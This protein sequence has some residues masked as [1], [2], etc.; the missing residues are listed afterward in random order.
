MDNNL[1]KSAQAGRIAAAASVTL[2]FAKAMQTTMEVD[3]LRVPLGVSTTINGLDG[4][5]DLSKDAQ[6][7][8]HVADLRFRKI[9]GTEQRTGEYRHPVGNDADIAWA[10]SAV[11]KPPTFYLADMLFLLRGN[12]VSL[13]ALVSLNLARTILADL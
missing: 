8:C 2:A 6:L 7:L 4:S 13:V 9:P 10:R 1:V 5:E 11:S 12:V 3:A